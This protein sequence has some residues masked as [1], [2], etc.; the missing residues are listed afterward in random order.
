ME[1]L[2]RYVED[3]WVLCRQQVNFLITLEAV[4]SVIRHVFCRAAVGH[5]ISDQKS[6]CAYDKLAAASYAV[7]IATPHY[8]DNDAGTPAWRHVAMATAAAATEASGTPAFGCDVK[9]LKELMQSRGC[10]SHDVICA[11]YDGVTGLCAR[12][13]SHPTQGKSHCSSGI[14]LEGLSCHMIHSATK[15]SRFLFVH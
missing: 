8:L 6:R 12:L 15:P 5:H 9:E 1:K 13:K 14:V 7:A 4:K 2:R 11:K 3:I 10:E